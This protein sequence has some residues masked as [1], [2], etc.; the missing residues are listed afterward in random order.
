MLSNI[1]SFIANFRKSQSGG[2]SVEAVI[3]FPVIFY[4][5]AAT[6]V[7]FDAFRAQSQAVKAAYTIGDVL[8][9]ETNF[10]SPNYLDS[11]W[12]IQEAM[13]TSFF[14][15]EMRVTIVRWTES[16]QSYHVVWSE[17]VGNV[18]P[19]NDATL[20]D[21]VEDF[22]PTLSNDKIVIA[23]ENFIE[24]VPIFEIGLDPFT[25]HN[26]VPTRPRFSTTQL[27]WNDNE[28]G[29]EATQTC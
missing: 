1:K 10:V 12:E 2:L 23:V 6:F 21:H 28:D 27:C 7:F 13:T 14:D 11:L 22:L 20:D 18:V 9:R 24:H 26:V 19:L 5:F 4:A 16:D 15:S 29:G 25:F 17:T 3:T 8:S